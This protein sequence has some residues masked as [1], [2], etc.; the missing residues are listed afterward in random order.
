VIVLDSLTSRKVVMDQTGANTHNLVGTNGCADAAST[1]RHPT[2]DFAGGHRFS[3][4][5]DEIGI[6]ITGVQ[7][8][9]T[10]IDHF[11]SGCTKLG[12]EIFFQ[13]KSAVI[14]GNSQAHGFLLTAL[15]G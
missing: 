8:V 4:G 15:R 12:N 5:D 10:E 9:S 2:L 7:G 13:A 11:M 3:E 1:N 6:V 14:R